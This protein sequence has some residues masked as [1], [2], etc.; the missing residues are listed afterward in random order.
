MGCG[1]NLLQRSIQYLL[2]IPGL[3][4]AE[5]LAGEVSEVGGGEAGEDQLPGAEGLIFQLKLPVGG[6]VAVLAVA[7]DGAADAC[8]V[9]TD[10]VGAAGDEPDLEQG[11]TAGDGNGLILGLHVLGT[12]LLVGHDL[13]DAPV[14]ILEQVA[15]QGAVW[16]GGAAKG[17]AEVG[18]FDLAV[19]DDLKEQLLGLGG[20]GNEDQTAGAGVQPVAEGRGVQIVLLVLTLLVEVEQST[21]EQG[22]V[23][24][25]IHG[26]ACRLVHHQDL[27]AV[28]DDLCRAAGVLPRRAFHPLVGIQYLV[29]DEQLDLVA[30][31]H[32][33]GKGMLFAVQLDLV[34]PQSLVQAARVQRRELLHQ[35]VVQ[36]GGGQ[37]FYF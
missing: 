22:V 29:Q 14:C 24:G 36:P 15:A 26:K 11:Q 5:G 34:L 3:R 16:R 6:V 28:V 23:L 7:Q 20:L 17:D 2:V 12:G 21:V 10:L 37:T 30:C 32:A 4:C 18:L 1:G 35:I 9:G 25:A 27:R 31:H 33:G 13:H 19:L 8:H